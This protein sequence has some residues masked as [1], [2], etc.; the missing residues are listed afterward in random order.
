[1]ERQLDLG[2]EYPSLNSGLSRH[3]LWNHTLVTSCYSFFHYKMR[4]TTIAA[5][6]TVN[7]KQINNICSHTKHSGLC[8]SFCWTPAWIPL[9]SSNEHL[10]WRRECLFTLPCISQEWPWITCDLYFLLYTFLY[11]PVFLQWSCI[12]FIHFMTKKMWV[13]FRGWS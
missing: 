13:N 9:A 12:H 10:N 11:F 3:K 6:L 2:S 8:S 1:M 4:M 7:E 5:S